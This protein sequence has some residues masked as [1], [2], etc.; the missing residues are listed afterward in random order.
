MPMKSKL[1]NADEL[2]IKYVVN[3]LD[4]SEEMLVEQAMMHD[5]DLL[6]EVESLRQTLKKC[7][8]LPIFDAPNHVIQAV[9]EKVETYTP[10]KPQPIGYRSFKRY[11]YAAAATVLISA[12]TVWYTQT[13]GE[14]S[15][16][17]MD[18]VETAN[19]SVEAQASPWIDNRDILHLNTAGMNSSPTNDSLNGKLRPID[20][21]S[22]TSRPARQLHLTGAQN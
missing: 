2:S 14:S 11:S 3:E 4:P 10:K 21:E 12:G 7:E 15:M 13:A 18:E 16:L 5:E 9:M 1:Q 20:G 19:Y 17:V 22:V 8:S 6:I